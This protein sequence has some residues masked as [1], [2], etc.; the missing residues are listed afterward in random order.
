MWKKPDEKPTEAQRADARHRAKA[1]L[2]RMTDE[3]DARIT[4]A[5]LADADA[6][7]VDELFRRRRGRPRAPEGVKKVPVSIKLDPDVVRVFRETGGGWQTRVNDILRREAAN[8]SRR[9][10][11][12]DAAVDAAKGVAKKAAKQAPKDKKPGTSGSH[13]ARGHKA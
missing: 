9:S 8:L 10:E 1:A 4:A 3:G 12:G 13:R 2:E 11:T 7:P 5:A 6:Q